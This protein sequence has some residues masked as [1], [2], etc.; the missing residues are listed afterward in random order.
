MQENELTPLELHQVNS[1][2]W[3][4]GVSSFGTQQLMT[5]QIVTTRSDRM[6]I[7]ALVASLVY[8][9]ATPIELE[10]VHSALWSFGVSFLGTR[11][12]MTGH[13]VT[14]LSDRLAIAALVSS[15]IKDPSTGM[16]SGNRQY[17]PVRIVK[18]GGATSGMLQSLLSSSKKGDRD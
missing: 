7:A 15:Y 6:A 17:N 4:F 9:W 5:G 12:L 16:A 13:L 2:C 14:S 18:S 10:Q 3:S 1:V 8:E 11:Q